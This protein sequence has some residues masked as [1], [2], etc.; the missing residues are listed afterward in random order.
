MFSKLRSAERKA[1]PW[2]WLWFGWTLSDKKHMS[3]PLWTKPMKSPAASACSPQSAL[4]WLKPIR[5]YTCKD[6]KRRKKKNPGVLLYLIICSSV[7][8]V[9]DRNEISDLVAELLFSMW[10]VFSKVMKST[11][12]CRLS[13]V[14]HHQH[15]HHQYPCWCCVPSG[16][17][18][19]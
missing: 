6:S 9:Q 16:K 2:M 3:D 7:W 8:P 5:L 17:A 13:K 4:M 12:F 18:K 11:W 19:S 14:L 1:K 15:H 10:W